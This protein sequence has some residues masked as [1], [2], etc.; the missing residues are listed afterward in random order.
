MPDSEVVTF[1]KH[2]GKP[3][4]ALL[5]DPDYARWLA[6]QE[7]FR[8]KFVS[9]YKLIQDRLHLDE[10]SPEHNAMQLRW[11]NPILLSRML[12]N[13]YAGGERH[14][15]LECDG[16]DISNVIPEKHGWDVQFRW[17]SGKERTSGYVELKP[18][19]GDDYPSVLRS[20]DAKKRRDDPD[21]D[22]F[23]VVGAFT[24]SVATEDALY[25]FFQSH[26]INLVHEADIEIGTSA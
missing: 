21:A 24:S 5:G 11:L 17:N 14:E 8:D 18:A 2:K 22:Y 9:L 23:L 25:A 20:M 3:V 7:W 6:A 13:I 10:D 4:E 12:L 19:M 16:E 15:Q 1:G 26:D